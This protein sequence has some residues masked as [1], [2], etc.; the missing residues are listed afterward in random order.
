M[1]SSTN[2]INWTKYAT[3]PVFNDPTW[4]HNSTENWGV[5]KVGT[6]YLMW[7]SDLNGPRQSG[8]ATS[9]NLTTLDGLYHRAHL[10]YQRRDVGLHLFAVLPVHV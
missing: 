5:I 4:A 6:Q 1:P 7:Y 9:T 8:I 2:G 10:H 3:N